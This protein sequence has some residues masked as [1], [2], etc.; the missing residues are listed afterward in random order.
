[1]PPFS[2]AAEK[3]ALLLKNFS[4]IKL[5][6]PA[7]EIQLDGFKTFQH[8]KNPVIYICPEESNALV[9]LYNELRI[10]YDINLYKSFRPHI[11]VAYRDLN[12][13]NY[14][15]AWSE[16][17]QKPFRAAFCVS[18]VNFYKRLP[19]TWEKVSEILLNKQA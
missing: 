18:K 7:F 4:N 19:T 17:Q 6:T 2:F 1:M 3:E 10:F 5:V 9:Q 12:I 14:E 15:K 8:I 16:Y 11:T 13:D